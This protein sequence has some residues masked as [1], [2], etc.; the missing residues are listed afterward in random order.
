M[1]GIVFATMI[2]LFSLA[3]VNFI[4]LPAGL[5]RSDEVINIILSITIKYKLLSNFRHPIQENSLL[6]EL[7]N[8]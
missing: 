6:R 8:I 4:T 1:A 7:M 2:V 3:Y 5:T